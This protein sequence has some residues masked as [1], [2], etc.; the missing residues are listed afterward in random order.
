MLQRQSA[1]PPHP[2]R[3]SKKK[4]EQVG[5]ETEDEGGLQNRSLFGWKKEENLLLDSAAFQNPF[6]VFLSRYSC[7]LALFGGT[8]PLFS[9]R[10]SVHPPSNCLSR[11]A[12]QPA[13]QAKGNKGAAAH[14]QKQSDILRLP[15]EA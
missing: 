12:K 9:N 2:Q 14:G 6:S 8:V 15:S 3:K 5:P 7:L 11:H 10:H 4:V 1:H 13:L